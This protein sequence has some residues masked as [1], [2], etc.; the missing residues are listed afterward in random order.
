MLLLAVT[1]IAARIAAEEF[2]SLV[3]TRRLKLI[4]GGESIGVITASAG[5]VSSKTGRIELVLEAVQLKL[6]EAVAN[7]GDEVRN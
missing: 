5:I 4:D 7:G 1:I 2:L 6:M 3:K